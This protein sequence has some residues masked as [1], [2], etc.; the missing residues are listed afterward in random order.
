[1]YCQLWD[2][3]YISS[4]RQALFSGSECFSYT[5]SFKD[6]AGVKSIQPFVQTGIVALLLDPANPGV[7][8]V[9][10]ILAYYEILPWETTAGGTAFNT[11]DDESFS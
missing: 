4:F 9:H 8:S 2:A 10:F 5:S 3:E 11:N 6:A 7:Y 1:L